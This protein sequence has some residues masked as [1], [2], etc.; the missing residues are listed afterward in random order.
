MPEHGYHSKSREYLDLIK[1]MVSL[2][3]EDRRHFLKFITGSPRLPIG[4]FGA[5]EPKMKV[6]LTRLKQ[7]EYPDDFLP[8]VM[9]CQNFLKMPPYTSYEILKEKFTQAMKEGQDNFTYS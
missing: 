3:K 1:F 4:G 6:V 8:S 2:E 5:L 9:T 7:E